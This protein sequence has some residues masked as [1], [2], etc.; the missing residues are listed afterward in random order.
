[1]TLKIDFG[2]GDGKKYAPEETPK[3]AGGT[4]LVQK[5][6]FDRLD[7][8]LRDYFQFVASRKRKLEDKPRLFW[9]HDLAQD[10]EVAFLKE[11]K[12]MLDF[13]KIIFVSNWQQ[14]QY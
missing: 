8:E 4:E 13:E 2:E 3:A 6:L 10:P 11:H 9:V 12:N 1:M 7:P 5:W 14:Y